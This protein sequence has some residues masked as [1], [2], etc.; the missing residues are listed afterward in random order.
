MYTYSIERHASQRIG[1]VSTFLRNVSN[2]HIEHL[3]DRR[4]AGSRFS[5]NIETASPLSSAASASTGRRNIPNDLSR[6]LNI[7]SLT[8]GK[9][10]VL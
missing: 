10:T 7:V 6:D 4:G 8:M 9:S 3:Q 5:I 1:I 2:F